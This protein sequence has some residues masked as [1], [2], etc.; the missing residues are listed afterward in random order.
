MLNSSYYKSKIAKLSKHL[1]GILDTFLYPTV[2]VFF[3][4][5]NRVELRESI[6]IRG[7]IEKE[8]MVTVICQPF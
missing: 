5:L 8:I 4:L 6:E 1:I 3:D 2:N 7:K